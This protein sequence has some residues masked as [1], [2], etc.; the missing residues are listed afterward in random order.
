[1]DNNETSIQYTDCCIVGSGPAGAVLGLLLARQGVKVTLLEAQKD[2]DRDFRGDS[3]HAAVMELMDKL[4]LAERLLELKHTKLSSISIQGSTKSSAVADFSR[5]K[6]RFPYITLIPNQHFIEFITNEAKRYPNFKLIMGAKVQ[7]LIEEDGKI[8][9]VGYHDINGWQE[10]RSLLTIGADGRS[11]RI[12]SLAGFESVKTSPP[13][14]I[15]WFRLPR[16]S[17]EPEG[18]ILRIGDASILGMA[19]RSDHWQISYII[20]KGSYPKLRNEGIENLQKALVK[21]V[22]ELADRV[23][24]LNDWTQCT[25]L[26][27]EASRVPKWHKSGLL[28]IGDAAHVMSPFGG[29]G[30]SYA[31]Q[32]AIAAANVLSTPLKT[33]KLKL[34]HLAR[35]QRLRDLP[36]RIIQIYQVIVQNQLVAAARAS[37][38]S[39]L[40][41]LIARIPIL[42]DIPARLIAFGLWPARLKS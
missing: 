41:D 42:R 10:V 11:S 9:G 15:L 4:G 38:P 18:V 17:D 8:S 5:L 22:P 40:A 34:E 32:D 2:F 16:R 14:D 29:V 27:V 26:S 28:L 13:S 3:L 36:T 12:R 19:D 25:L 39:P 33:H 7:K 23:A 30:I 35:V 31:I 21:L 6:S 1:M 24:L 37:E 20:P